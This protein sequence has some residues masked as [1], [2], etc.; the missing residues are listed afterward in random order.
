MK[1]KEVNV[2]N[3]DAEYKNKSYFSQLVELDLS[4]N[5]I[6]KIP[7]NIKMLALLETVDFSANPLTRIPENMCAL[8][9]STKL[10]WILNNNS[11][12]K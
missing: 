11:F 2:S 9:V 10:I 5:D 7:D 1:Q 12:Y 4:R 8:T 3:W 6:P